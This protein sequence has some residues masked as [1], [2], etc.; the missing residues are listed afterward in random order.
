MAGLRTRI[1]HWLE[2]RDAAK[3]QRRAERRERD[4]AKKHTAPPSG[5]SGGVGPG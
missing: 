3:K 5:S 2:A 4:A 1:R